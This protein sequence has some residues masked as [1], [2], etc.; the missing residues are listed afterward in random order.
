MILLKLLT[1]IFSHYG[2]IVGILSIPIYFVL[3]EIVFSLII[4]NGFRM[5]RT[6]ISEYVQSMQMIFKDVNARWYIPEVGS[7][8]IELR[9]NDESQDP[10]LQEEKVNLIGRS[11]REKD[12]A[13]DFEKEA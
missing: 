6:R 12:A 9:L 2:K 13:H 4:Q 7:L 10:N 11:V 8:W 1:M 3:T 5:T